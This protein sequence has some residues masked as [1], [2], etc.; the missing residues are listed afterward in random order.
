MAE[1]K[2]VQVRNMVDH[3][4]SYRVDER[5]VTRRFESGEVKNIP[6]GELRALSYKR[7]GRYLLQHYLCVKDNELKKDFNIPEDLIEY[8]Y[9][10]ADVDRILLNGSIEELEDTLDFAPDGIIELVKSRAYKLKIPDT[11]K[12]QVI[13]NFTGTDINKQIELKEQ[14]ELALA[15]EG[16]IT[17]SA[18]T[19]AV[20]QPKRKRRVP[21]TK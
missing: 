5:G 14:A 17:E 10:E 8:D 2:V 6:E 19:S 1:E 20:E 7:G 16:G 15:N 21:V 18:E 3:P 11:N 12:R 4:V 9:T 13:H